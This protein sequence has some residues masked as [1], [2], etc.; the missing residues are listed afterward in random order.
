[1]KIRLT[2][3][4]CEADVHFAYAYFTLDCGRGEIEGVSCGEHPEVF[5]VPEGF[6]YEW[7]RT[8]D[9]DRTIVGTADSLLIAPDDTAVT[10]RSVPLP[11]PASLSPPQTIQ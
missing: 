3:K 8:Y 4:A 10:S 2:L 11:F 1:M 7:Y 9:P 5:R 6:L